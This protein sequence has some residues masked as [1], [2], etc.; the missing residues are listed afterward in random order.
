[1]YVKLSRQSFQLKH[2]SRYCVSKILKTFYFGAIFLQLSQKY[3]YGE[4]Q[5]T[6]IRQ[7]YLNYRKNLSGVKIK[8]I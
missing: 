1:M 6:F 3:K 8:N 7:V 4:V 5:Q 2:L